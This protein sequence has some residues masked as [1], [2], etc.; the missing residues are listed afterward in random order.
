M[1][2]SVSAVSAEALRAGR[3]HR[4]GDL[5]GGYHRQGDTEGASSLF[6]RFQRQLQQAEN[7]WLLGVFL[8]SA[9]FNV[10]HNYQQHEWAEIL[11]QGGLSAWRD[12]QS[13]DNGTGIIR[14]LVGLGEI[15]AIQG[16]AARAGWLFGAAD[17]LTPV[18]GFYR[19][20][21]AE[22]AAGARARLDPNATAAF[23][24]AWAEG[25]G[26][27]LEQA[28]QKTLLRKAAL[29]IAEVAS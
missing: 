12:I 8:V 9:A 19:Q 29:E 22:R 1:R 3:L 21:L 5:D 15:A 23:E 20:S 13:L 28:M 16:L 27:T 6:Q 17:H 11:Y 7:R 18:S 25:Q 10:Q 26:A 4:A 14:G 2:G 24:T